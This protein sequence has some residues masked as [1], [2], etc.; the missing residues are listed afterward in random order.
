MR[1]SIGLLSCS[2]VI[3]TFSS[4]VA[5]Q[6]EKT[7]PTNDEILLVLTQTDRAIQQYSLLIDQEESLMSPKGADA[8]A[9]DRETVR[10]LETAVKAFRLYPQKFNGPLGFAFFEW[11]DDAS[12]NANLCA[13]YAASQAPLQITP[14]DTSKA[15]SLVHLAQSC[16]DASTLLYTVS[17]NAG[18]LYLRYVSASE[19]TANRCGTLLQQCTNILRNKPAPK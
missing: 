15:E 10:G 3:L 19:D 13:T 16:S 18:A 12:R 6:T 4:A 14:R 2:F 7:F 1:P 11:I 9:K 8:V 5:G 17:E